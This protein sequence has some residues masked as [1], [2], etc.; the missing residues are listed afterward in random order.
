MPHSLNSEVVTPNLRIVRNR[1]EQRQKE[2]E[3]APQSPVKELPVNSIL[4]VW[5][6]KVI[7]MK[8]K[9][10]IKVSNVEIVKGKGIILA[11][12]TKNAEAQAKGKKKGSK[13]SK[14]QLGF[15]LTHVPIDTPLTIR[16]K[17]AAIRGKGGTYPELSAE[18]GAFMGGGQVNFGEVG[19]TVVRASVNKPQVYEFNV[20]PENFPFEPNKFG[21][22][23]HVKI[24]NVYERGTSKLT[25]DELP[26]CLS[27][28]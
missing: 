25:Y 19:H 18:I 3:K 20:R 6:Q 11:G 7:G 23:Q 17:A 22:D 27:N 15:V 13:S 21:K 4:E 2:D 5:L 24:T 8:G 16:V 26:N 28:L 10:S 12:E 9:A 14:P 1:K